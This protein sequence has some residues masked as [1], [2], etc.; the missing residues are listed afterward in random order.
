MKFL[1][2]V[3]VTVCL[4]SVVGCGLLSVKDIDYRSGSEYVPALE[5]PPGM[6]LP[7]SI[8]TYKVPQPASAPLEIVESDVVKKVG[9]NGVNT[10]LV[11]DGYDKTWRRVGLAIEALKLEVADMDRSKGIYYLAAIKVGASL[12][13]PKEAS[14]T[15][16][17]YRVLVQQDKAFCSV[18]VTAADGISDDSS[19]AILDAL[20]SNIQP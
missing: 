16:T 6:T 17:T 10:L 7:P 14:D 15:P 5:V 20:Y 13:L 12:V 1:Q 8:D 3:I 19:K 11:K 2:G 9:E 4:M 18:L